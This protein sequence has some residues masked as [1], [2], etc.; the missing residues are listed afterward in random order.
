MSYKP[1]HPDYC[2]CQTCEVQSRPSLIAQAF[3]AKPALAKAFPRAELAEWLVHF[4]RMENR[5]RFYVDR[6]ADL[7]A[8]LAWYDGAETLLDAF[9]RE[10]AE[11]HAT[12]ESLSS[13]L[14]RL[15]SLVSP[16]T[17][18]RDFG[19]MHREIVERLR[20]ACILDRDGVHCAYIDPH[21]VLAVADYLASL[22]SGSRQ[23]TRREMP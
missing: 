5:G 8:A 22:P 3:A 1:P 23:S 16:T 14:S 17:P 6:I 21:A 7:R 2:K 18:A 9:R 15:R 20:A 19:A 11:L 10:S 13:E 12:V 4:E